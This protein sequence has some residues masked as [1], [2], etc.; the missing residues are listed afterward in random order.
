MAEGAVPMRVWPPNLGFEL[1]GVLRG[2][3]FLFTTP[4][5]DR[6]ITLETELGMAG[7]RRF[8]QTR[9]ARLAGDAHLE[10]LAERRPFA[11]DVVF[12]PGERRITYD[13]AFTGDDGSSY[14]IRGQTDLWWLGFFDALTL[15]PASLYDGSGREIGRAMLRFDAARELGALVRSFRLTRGAFRLGSRLGRAGATQED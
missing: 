7:L 5:V 14:A 13:L 3:F 8:A 9:S 10:G 4:E 6:A 12:R 2:T 1:S 15:L 11:G